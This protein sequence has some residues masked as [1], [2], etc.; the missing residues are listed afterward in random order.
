MNKKA[1]SLVWIVI[2]IF[3]LSI[4][5]L[6]ISNILWNSKDLVAKFS[7][8]NNLDLLTANAYNIVWKLN[9]SSLIDQ[10]V[11]YIYKN[12]AT[13]KFEIKIWEQNNEYKYI[14]KAFNK[15]DNP[16]N[17]K[18]SL[19]SHIFYVKILHINW[20][21]RKAVKALIKALN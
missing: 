21:E 14:D 20:E 11:F 9:T 8:R 18:W 15:I 12:K 4:V 3:I 10:D 6:W 7:Q 5:I 16:W 17:F 13:H 19:F 1:E 2:G